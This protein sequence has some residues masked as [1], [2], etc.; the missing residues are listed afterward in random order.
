MSDVLK[1]RAYKKW[2][3]RMSIIIRILI[4]VLIV[5][6]LYYAAKRAYVFGYE[7]F[8]EEAKELPPGRDIAVVIPED[9]DIS[10]IARILEAEGLIDDAKLF[11]I[12]ERISDSHADPVPGSYIL[13]TSM[14]GTEILEKIREGVY[15]S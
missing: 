15:K 1:E 9:A 7:L 2:V 5:L 12:R 11:V 6:A 10:M 8:R 4:Y 13:N 14:T 3:S